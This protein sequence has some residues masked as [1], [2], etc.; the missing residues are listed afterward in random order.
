MLKEC[1]CLAGGGSTAPLG[2]STSGGLPRRPAQYV[3]S[4]DLESPTVRFTGAG[5]GLVA[6]LPDSFHGMQAATVIALVRDVGISGSVFQAKL[7]SGLLIRMPSVSTNRTW[8]VISL[9]WQWSWRDGTTAQVYQDGVALVTI[10]ATAATVM[11]HTGICIGC[12]FA[13]DVAEILVLDGV[14]GEQQL[15]LYEIMVAA[16]Q[17][18]SVRWGDVAPTAG[19]VEECTQLAAGETGQITCR[20]PGHVITGVS[21]ASFGRPQ[22][23]CGAFALDHECHAL[24]SYEQIMDRCVGRSYCRVSATNAAFATTSCPMPYFEAA[25][26]CCVGDTNFGD[27]TYRFIAVRDEEECRWQ[28]AR[29]P[30]CVAYE[31]QFNTNCEIHTEAVRLEVSSGWRCTCAAKHFHNDTL[32]TLSAQVLCAPDG[33]EL[34]PP[35]AERGLQTTPPYLPPQLPSPTRRPTLAPSPAPIPQLVATLRPVAASSTA[36]TTPSTSAPQSISALLESTA[37]PRSITPAT[38]E[39]TPLEANC[40]FCLEDRTCEKCM[41]SFYLHQG[42]CIDQ[43]PSGTLPIGRGRFS[44]VC[45]S[46]LPATTATVDSTM[47]QIDAWI[48]C[49]EKE[50][51]CRF[52]NEVGT[53]CT[54]CQNSHYLVEALGRCRHVCPSGMHGVGNG[55][56]GRRCVPS[57]TVAASI[58]RPRSSSCHQCSD[59]STVCT[60]CRDSRY[61]TIAGTCENAC[62]AGNP[63]GNGRYGRRCVGEDTACV[64]GR[65]HCHA[66]SISEAS[67]CIQC[68]DR[69][70]LHAGR[71]RPS[72]PG[73]F[74]PQGRGNYNRVCRS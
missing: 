1:R 35:G 23:N 5:S 29:D 20:T 22:G 62:L 46:E 72:C 64:A 74:T 60:L 15:R 6:P 32:M 4:T 49:R 70:Y 67:F 13:G 42:V 31:S 52:C 11:M 43:C 33:V 47:V 25:D 59:D 28:C 39:C 45:L 63:T 58:C 66:C 54:R 53:M 10:S 24:S 18:R 30:D 40:R 71:C 26:G 3:A 68:R 19:L 69:H 21:F 41:N 51:N 48:P 7:P 73:G 61:L 37:T 65:Q 38:L 8:S 34:L 9:T 56:F 14:V 12:D 57:T 44:R 16:R 36:A 17:W 27:G 55:R 50:E 2:S